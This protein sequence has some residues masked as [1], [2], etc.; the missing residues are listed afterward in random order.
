MIRL[1]DRKFNAFSHDI[2]STSEES[3]IQQHPFRLTSF[4]TDIMLL[5]SSNLLSVPTIISI[6][7]F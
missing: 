2:V 3:S 6:G 1:S 5:R 7:L 4:S